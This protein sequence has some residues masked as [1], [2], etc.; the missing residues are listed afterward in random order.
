MYDYATDDVTDPV[1]GEVLLPLCL[2]QTREP[3]DFGIIFKE[4]FLQFEISLHMANLPRTP[5]LARSA[6]IEF[7]GILQKENDIVIS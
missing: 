1:V 7:N 4:I 5:P 6:K 2:L 3:Q